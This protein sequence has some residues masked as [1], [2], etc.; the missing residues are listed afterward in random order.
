MNN[1]TRQID[2]TGIR[3]SFASNPARLIVTC[4]MLLAITGPVRA[5]QDPDL[6]LPLYTGKSPMIHTIQE[7]VILNMFMGRPWPTSYSRIPWW[8]RVRHRR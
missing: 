8:A 5:V 3:G 6:Q 7:E 4:L 1:I 2:N